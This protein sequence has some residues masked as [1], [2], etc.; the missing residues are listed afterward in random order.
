MKRLVDAID[1]TPD[2]AYQLI[3]E[4]RRNNIKYVVAPYEADA[5]LAYLS[6]AGIADL[7][8]TEDGDLLVF[9]AKRI[10]YKLDYF[11]LTGEE[12][13]LDEMRG[14]KDGLCFEWFTHCM[15]MTI[16]IMAGCDYLNQIS[17]IGLK[18]A[19]KLMSKNSTFK[20]ALEEIQG[21]GKNVPQDY[22]SNFIQAFLTFRFQRVYCP[23]RKQCV[24]I[25]DISLLKGSVD[26][27][28]NLRELP[29]SE[30]VL[31]PYVLKYTKSRK[32]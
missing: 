20:N 19:H 9:G 23:I 10:I 28:P 13:C 26:S 27:L 30:E 31:D 24:E 8:I 11:E 22:V 17:G 7:I 12:I 15:F 29:W 2:V 18:T 3:L 5:Q 4:L 1:I 32:I 21:G 6:R 16:C 25:N 14:S